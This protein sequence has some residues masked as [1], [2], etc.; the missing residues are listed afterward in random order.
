MNELGL[1]SLA[2]F[3]ANRV[4]S[5]YYPASWKYFCAA[6]CKSQWTVTCRPE[7]LFIFCTCQ[8]NAH[9]NRQFGKVDWEMES[10]FTIFDGEPKML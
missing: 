8:S 2:R 6:L 7:H 5:L 4:V 1:F 3:N 9:N 10:V